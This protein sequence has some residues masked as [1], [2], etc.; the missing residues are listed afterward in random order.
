MLRRYSPWIFCSTFSSHSFSF[1]AS[2]SSIFGKSLKSTRISVMLSR[3]PLERHTSSTWFMA[4]FKSL[5]TERRE[6]MSEHSS[7]FSS[8]S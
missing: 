5:V 2:S 6:R 1:W 7:S 8:T 4:A 3:E